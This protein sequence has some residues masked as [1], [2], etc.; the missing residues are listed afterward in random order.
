MSSKIAQVTIP[1]PI[2]GPFDYSMDPDLSDKISVGHRV[3]V[4]FGNQK[5][6]GCVV[7]IKA[8]STYQN[9]KP[10]LKLLDQAPALDKNF[11]RFTKEFS[12]YYCCSWGEAIETV[13]PKALRKPLKT[14]SF[15]ENPILQNAKN[16]STITL[17]R[18]HFSDKA[19]DFFSDK[20]ESALRQNL[21]VLFLVPE[22]ALMS[23]VSQKLSQKNLNAFILDKRWNP[24]RE[25]EQWLQIKQD[26]VKL[27]VGTRST[28]FS[29]TNRLGLII[30][31]DENNSA[32]KQDQ[33]PF[34]HLRDVVLL[35]AKIEHCD[36]IF[37][38]MMPSLEIWTFA[39]G[40]KMK[41]LDFSTEHSSSVH[42]MDMNNYNPRKTSVVSFFLKDQ[43]RKTLDARGKAILFM[44]RK[45]FSTL[46]RCSKCGHTL[47][48]E[49]CDVG[50]TYLFEKKKMVC[51]FCNFSTK[52]TE[53]C[54]ACKGAYLRYQGM[55]IEKLESEL[56]R[57]FPQARIDHY[58]KD[59]RIV[60]P[61]FDILIATQAIL[62]EQGKLSV[63]LVGILQADNEL[64][65]LD[66]RASEKAFEVFMQLK[67]MASR[68]FVVQTFMPDNDCIKALKKSDIEKFYRHELK[69]RKE[70]GFPPAKHLIE[71]MVR[72]PKQESSIEC[73][74][75]FF[76]ELKKV[77]ENKPVEI[78]DPQ[79]FLTPRLRGK[80]RLTI[81]MKGKK[82][83]D[84]V[85]GIR[86]ALASV[87]KKAG[88]QISVNVDP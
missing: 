9:L 6:V 87:K 59:K 36:V 84:M 67:N 56:S 75:D 22:I 86:S 23:F 68:Q 71:I 10:I 26:R 82:V 14:E 57:D 51:R 70:L 77:F 49:K 40:K 41:S 48:C 32:Y 25:L 11:L 42:V 4:P 72:A 28:V 17:V 81:L 12:D 88:V 15:W 39:Q 35:R 19:W 62:R 73:A 7:G 83:P 38:S 80:Y 47:K 2:P 74:E 8:K 58:D 3:L 27:L 78:F 5:L 54:P 53:I 18:N 44:N 33:S 30:V 29:P 16:S 52:P 43:L 64:N 13:L 85:V 45:G 65:R 66:F 37:T 20:I 79:P 1:L 46:I 63:E 60:S 55:G 34:Y 76:Q 69:I 61:D 31:W 50:L 21:S 24:K